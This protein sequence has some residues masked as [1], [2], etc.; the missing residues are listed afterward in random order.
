MMAGMG[1]KG[2]LTGLRTLR[3]KETDRID[4]LRIE[5]EKTNVK[6]D[7]LGMEDLFTQEGK[8]DLH[9][10]PEFDTYE[11]HR[12]AMAL[13]SLAVY[14]PIQINQPDV[15]KKSY[16]EFWKDLSLLGFEIE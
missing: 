3:I 5:L 4:A 13:A 10:F 6:V 15:V 14:G 8:S 1:I 7:D 12:M 2:K 16:P 9:N 11:D